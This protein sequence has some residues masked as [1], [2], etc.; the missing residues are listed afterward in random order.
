MSAGKPPRSAVTQSLT[1]HHRRIDIPIIKKMGHAVRNRRV[2][3]ISSR[4]HYLPRPR[5]LLHCRCVR[6]SSNLTDAVRA[7][8]MA[9]I[10]SEWTRRSGQNSRNYISASPVYSLESGSH[11]MAGTRAHTKQV[12]LQP[13]ND[14]QY[15]SSHSGTLRAPLGCVERALEIDV[16]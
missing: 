4:C 5:E 6:S 7:Q 16:A 9:K 2:T 1:A 8:V 14:V 3:F 10:I 13:L 11:E 12:A 15:H